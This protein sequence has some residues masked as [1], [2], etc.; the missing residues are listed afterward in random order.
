MATKR[1]ARITGAIIILMVSLSVQAKDTTTEVTQRLQTLYPATTITSVRESRIAGLFEVVMGKNIAYTDQ[2][3]RYL[4]FGHLFDMTEQRDLTAELLETL[5]RVNVATLPTEDA[6]EVVRGEGKHRLFVFSDPDCP[7]CRQ[8]EDE[9][10]RLTNVSIHT[11]LY[12]IEQLHPEAK[13][14]AHRVWCA[15]DR[16]AAWEAL[17]RQ[18]ALPDGDYDCEHPIARNIAL[19]ERLGINAT[20]TLILEDGT[21]VQGYQSA[22]EIEALLTKLNK[23]AK[24]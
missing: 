20:P 15:Q 24:P 19:A 14:K 18:N 2:S 13:D 3:A 17:M 7:Y 21:L 5:N 22:A 23:G 9:L 12:P 1:I 11:F 16:A 6:I 10:P 8:L 4:I